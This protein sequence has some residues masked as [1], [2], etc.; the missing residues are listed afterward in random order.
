MGPDTGPV[1]TGHR[2]ITL[3]K[4]IPKNGDTSELRNVYKDGFVWDGDIIIAP[5]QLLL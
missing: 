2:T 4:D 5:P 3:D 1:V